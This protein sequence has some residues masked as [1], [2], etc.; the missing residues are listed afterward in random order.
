MSDIE[1]KW[2]DNR[3]VSGGR[4]VSGAFFPGIHGAIAG[5]P[6]KKLHAAGAEVGG[7]A[8]V[9]IVGGGAGTYAA[10]KMGWYKSQGKVKSK[11]KVKKNDTLSAFGVDHGL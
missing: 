4:V 11:S 6:G 3:R 7:G 9:P 1:K 10:G 5:R 8:V 2:D